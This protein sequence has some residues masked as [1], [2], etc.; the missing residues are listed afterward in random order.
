MAQSTRPLSLGP[1]RPSEEPDVPPPGESPASPSGRFGRWRWRIGR[2]FGITIYVHAT[3]LLLLLWVGLV[4]LPLGV[5]AALDGVALTVAVFATVVLHELSHALT[6]R[7]FGIRTREIVLLPIGGVSSLERMPD[8]PTQELVITLAGPATNVAIALLL[9]GL[10][11]VRGGALALSSLQVTGGPFLTKFMWINVSLAVFNLLPAFPMDGGR[12]L[13]AALALR[14]SYARATEVAA[15]L[16]QAMALLFGLLGLFFNP[17][18][19]LIALFIWMGAQQE[20]SVVQLRAALAG[21]SVKDAMITDY[22]VVDRRDPLAK[23][24][25]LTLA[26]FQHDFP[27]VEGNGAV[28]V[29]TRSDLVRGLSAAG[30]NAPVEEWMHRDFE[31]AEPGEMLEPALS[32]LASR[33][34]TTLVVVK[35]GEVRG[36]VTPENVGELVLFNSAVRERHRGGSRVLRASEPPTHD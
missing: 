35:N 11:R 30:N 25:E 20:S 12:V 5:R 23:A 33:E 22:R 29:L 14:M 2:P 16:G 27:V 19:V 13:R 4:N 18:L 26:G 36:I 24:V 8:K 15:H 1:D 34:T 32:K 6:A 3:F 7:R 9:F 31:T 10:I 17:L 28:G 21:L